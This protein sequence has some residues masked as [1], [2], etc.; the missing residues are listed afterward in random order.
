[1]VGQSLIVLL[2][3]LLFSI[4]QVTCEIIADIKLILVGLALALL[5]DLTIL[6]FLDICNFLGLPL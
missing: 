3:A 1:M 2:S 6:G 5:E 4:L